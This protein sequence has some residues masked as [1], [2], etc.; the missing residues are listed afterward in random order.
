MTE[1]NIPFED[2]NDPNIPVEIW[3]QI[4]AQKLIGMIKDWEGRIPQDEDDTLY[5]LALR[6]AVD[7]VRG[8]PVDLGL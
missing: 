1:M 8:I 3:K 7:V 5:T 2:T 4:V 6:R